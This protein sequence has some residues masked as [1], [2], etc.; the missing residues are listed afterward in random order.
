[1]SPKKCLFFSLLSLSPGAFGCLPDTPASTPSLAYCVGTPLSGFEM[2]SNRALSGPPQIKIDNDE[3]ILNGKRVC[4]WKTRTTAQVPY[5]FIK[6]EFLVNCPNDLPFNMEGKTDRKG[7][8]YGIV[9]M[10][11]IGRQG[12]VVEVRGPKGSLYFDQKKYHQA[13]KYVPS[14]DDIEREK[15]KAIHDQ[16]FIALRSRFAECLSRKDQG[17]LLAIFSK[18]P[19]FANN[20]GSDWLNEHFCLKNGEKKRNLKSD[21]FS[22]E[23]FARCLTSPSGK[24]MIEPL[25]KALE[26]MQADKVRISSNLSADPMDWTLALDV[27][28]SGEK[29]TVTFKKT[30]SGYV[31]DEFGQAL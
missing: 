16:R 25:V 26:Q 18:R 17:C 13:I 6:T 19:D 9:R 4:L 29:L 30:K 5:T 28:V 14:K 23:E 11:A 3:V 1:M 8:F 7:L 27:R 24:P 20:V 10:P 22:S 12:T 15:E 2:F 21:E 31:V